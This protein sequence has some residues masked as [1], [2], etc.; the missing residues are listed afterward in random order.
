MKQINNIFYKA[1]ILSIIIVCSV[2]ASAQTN[3]SQVVSFMQNKGWAISADNNFQYAKAT[4][5]TTLEYYSFDSCRKYAIVAFSRNKD[6]K[7]F[8]LEVQKGD[9]EE[10][11]K[12]YN[13]YLLANIL[14]FKGA[15]YCF[16]PGENVR[17]G[18]RINTNSPNPEYSTQCHYMI[19]Y[20]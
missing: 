4:K 2:K 9:G 5:Q 8:D 1:I 11:T 18:I 16:K 12:K 17:F 19:F 20:K 7:E 15:I 14:P 13:T 6:V 10:Y 3:Y